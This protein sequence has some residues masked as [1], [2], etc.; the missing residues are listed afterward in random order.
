[1]QVKII[2]VA[3]ML[4]Y[5]AVSF[6]QKSKADSGISLF[7]REAVV[8]EWEDPSKISAEE[9]I[10]RYFKRVESISGCGDKEAYS[11]NATSKLCEVE[12]TSDRAARVAYDRLCQ[13]SKIERRGLLRKR[14]VLVVP[15]CQLVDSYD[16]DDSEID[17]LKTGNWLPIEELKRSLEKIS[18]SWTTVLVL[19]LN[20]SDDWFVETPVLRRHFTEI[21]SSNFYTFKDLCELSE[22][23][24]SKNLALVLELNPNQC[25]KFESAVGHRVES[26]EGE[27]VIISIVKEL[28]SSVS[29][30]KL[31]LRVPKSCYTTK[32]VNVNNNRLE[33]IFE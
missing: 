2:F 11:I 14:N 1:M 19:K 22:Y 30:V 9:Y 4:L 7:K 33:L 25:V 32:L 16:E 3:L 26:L 6:A 5:S 23:A 10:S 17:L 13:I 20:D 29:D 18:S 31:R 24:K 15:F 28:L 21:E 27:S 12:Y 8:V